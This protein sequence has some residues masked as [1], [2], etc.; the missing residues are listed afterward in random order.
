MFLNQTVHETISWNPCR[1]QLFTQFFC[2]I[3]LR[4]DATPV[5]ILQNH[6]LTR[7][8]L[9]IICVL[10]NP[11]VGEQDMLVS[12]VI[13]GSLYKL[14]QKK[15]VKE[16]KNNICAISHAWF[17][18]TTWLQVAKFGGSSNHM[19]REMD[20]DIFRHNIKYLSRF[21]LLCFFVVVATS[22]KSGDE[23]SRDSTE[24]RACTCSEPSKT[25]RL[26]KKSDFA[27]ETKKS[28]K[29]GIDWY[30]DAKLS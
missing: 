16:I 21:A 4:A 1:E 6:N 2:L 12:V 5:E 25:S 10:H 22:G 8:N 18:C 23:D 28:W 24:E 11:A 7:G 9:F 14:S 26:R 3:I 20:A 13:F 19:F 30:L 17:S 29:T 15:K 27:T